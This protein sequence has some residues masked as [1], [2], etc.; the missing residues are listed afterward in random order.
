MKKIIL[1]I[2]VLLCSCS[3]TVYVPVE[4]ERVKIETKKEIQKDSIFFDRVTHVE[5]KG[6]TVF[7]TLTEYKFVY[8]HIRDTVLR[9]DSIP[10]VI[11]QPPEI[12]YKTKKSKVQTGIIYMLVV[13]CASL[14]LARKLHL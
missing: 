6:D 3:R 9:V 13:I 7:N 10:V 12:I 8:S 1:V 5:T 14:L 11:T 4:T 2:L